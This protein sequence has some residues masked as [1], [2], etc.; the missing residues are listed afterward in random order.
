M[1]E[2]FYN[3][4]D[5]PFGSRV[6]SITNPVESGTPAAV[7]YVAETY[8]VNNPS[9]IKERRGVKGEPTGS[10]GVRDFVTG[11]ATVQLETDETPLVQLG[12][13]F[14]EDDVDYVVTDAPEAEQAGE[15]KKQQIQFRKKYAAPPAP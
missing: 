8:N 13:T 14:T 3:D 15:I 5:L 7:E 1:S 4:G 9:Q 2:P 11:S 12:A 6:L 10:L